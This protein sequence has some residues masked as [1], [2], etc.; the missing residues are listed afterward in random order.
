MTTLAQMA[1]QDSVEGNTISST[2]KTKKRISGAKRWM[3]T[4]NNYPEDW[5]AQMAPCLEGVEWCAGYEVGEK[6]TP[7]V[8]GYAEFPE[9][10]RP[11]GY[12]GCPK[13][14][15]W[16]DK[17]GKP[18]KGNRQHCVNYCSK[19]GKVEPK[20]TLKPPKGIK[21]WP[22]ERD[23]QKKILAEIEEEPDDRCIHW[24]WSK[25]GGTRKTSTCKYLAVKKNAIV[26]GGKAA[27]VRNA[28]CEYKKTNGET[29]ELIVINIPKSFAAEYVSYEAFENIK[30]MCFYSGKYEGGMVV[31]NS[32]HL[33]IFANFYPDVKKMTAEGRW[34]ITNIDPSDDDLFEDI[35]VED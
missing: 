16:G 1:P 33:Y 31:G 29:P 30:D 13:D 25:T 22:M 21:V 4:W 12:R 14:V 9:K 6:G 10:V 20:S 15:H 5:L 2:S 35:I 28:I 7:H 23:W 8:Q 24:I 34:S 17:D 27:D 18:C 3:F 11:I 26:L 19:D 32:P